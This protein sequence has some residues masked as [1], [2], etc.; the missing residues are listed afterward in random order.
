MALA[1]AAVADGDNILSTLDIVRPRQLHDERL[2]QRWQRGEVE[3][4]EAFNGREPRRLDAPLDHAALAPRARMRAIFQRR[5]FGRWQLL[6]GE[7]HQ[8]PCIID[9]LSAALAALPVIPA[10]QAPH[11]L[12][13]PLLTPRTLAPAPPT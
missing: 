5:P 1:R 10:Q 8:V 7:T 11:L 9:T 13:P 6:F 4:V 2:V 12:P 3:G